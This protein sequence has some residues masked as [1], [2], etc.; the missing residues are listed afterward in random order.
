[1]KARAIFFTGIGTIAVQETEIPE[2]AAGEVLVQAAYSCISPGTEMRCLS[3]NQGRA[4]EW[5]FIPGYALVGKI[6]AKGANVDLA[7]GTTVFCTGTTRCGHN[8]LWGGHVSHAVAPADRVF[9]IPEN[10]S[11]EEA[12]L[13]KLAAITLRGIRMSKPQPSETVAVV[14]LGPIGHLAARLHAVSGARVVGADTIPERVAALKRAGIEAVVATPDTIA[15]TV[16]AV[17]PQGADIVVDATGVSAA[18]RQAILL[19]RETP[20][21]DTPMAPSRYLIQG[22]YPE[23]VSLPY[24]EFFSRE[25]SVLFSR[26]TRPQDFRDVFDLMSRGRLSLAGILGTPFE[27]EEAPGVYEALQARKPGLLTAAFR[28]S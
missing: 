9:V 14:G 6:I 7:E 21:D 20:T 22:S 16:R 5:P 11:L 17:L 18:A 10:I 4:P 23:E 19:A 25:A 3:G 15:S 13:A 1:M 26:D 28:W 27:A 24:G 8:R 2:P 12:V